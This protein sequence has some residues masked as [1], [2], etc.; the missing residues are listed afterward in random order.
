VLVEE[1]FKVKED[2]QKV[3]AFLRDIDKASSC[4]P[5]CERI[6][7][8]DEKNFLV[9]ARAKVAYL[10]VKFKIKVTILEENPPFYL[11]SVSN[12]EEDGKAGYFS[13]KN[14]L[15]LTEISP[16]ETEIYYRSEVSISGRIATFG[17]RII[18]AKTQ[19]M[20]DEFAKNIRNAIEGI[21]AEEKIGLWSRLVIWFWRV[22][23]K[24]R[25]LLVKTEK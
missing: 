3:W 15:K 1:S 21:P 4:I 20:A 13:Q 24:V 11:S 10:S 6:E 14:T 12:G 25:S 17:Q 5:G 19:E 18:R 16:S 2:I 9:I 8:L 22:C 23:Q 7:A